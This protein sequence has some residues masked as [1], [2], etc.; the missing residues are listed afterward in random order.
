[1]KTFNKGLAPILLLVLVLLPLDST[2]FARATDRVD[3]QRTERASERV[4]A[5]EKDENV[6]ETY[7]V[8]SV[9]PSVAE[10]KLEVADSLRRA[11]D[12]RGRFVDDEV[13]VKFS[14]TQ[15]PVRVGLTSRTVAEA[16]A[17]YGQRDDVEY[18]EPNY[19]ATAF[20]TP[21]D[22][23][24]AYQWN[25]DNETTD[26]VNAEAAWDQATGEGAVVAVV[27]TGVA[28]ENY[29]WGFWNR[30]YQAPDL[31]DTNFVSGYD[32][33]NNDSHP[34]DDEGH[35]THVAGTIAGATNNGEGVA[36]LAHGA[37]IMPVKVLDA[38]GSGSYYDVAEG[39]RFAADN[40]ADVINLSLGGPSGASYLEDAV[41][42]AHE[43]GVTVVA[44]A[45]N[46][47]NGSVSYPAAYDDYVIAVGATR[48]DETL[49]SYSN[50]G[51]S[52]DIVAP[53]GDVT[54]DQNG[55]GYGDGVLQ[56]TFGS[57]RDDFGYY[58]YQG[59]SMAAPHVAA[60]AAMVMA[61][62]VTDPSEVQIILE[63]SADD[64]GANGR[65][66]TFG[67]GLLN[68]AAAL[69]V[70][71]ILEPE[72]D[73][74]PNPEPEPDTPPTVSITEPT[75]SETVS[76]EVQVVATAGDDNGVDQVEFYV[77]GVLLITD[78]TSP[79]SVT[80][81]S[82]AVA[83]GNHELMAVA[84]DTIDQSE[85]ESV[86]V[87]VDNFVPPVP[88]GEVVVFFESFE[89]GLGEWVRDNQDQWVADGSQATDGSESAEVD[90]NAVDT[91][92]TS[93]AVSLNGKD[94]ARISFDWLIER[95]LDT[96]EYLAFDL[97]TDGGASWQEQARLRG[98]QDR[99]DRWFS[100]ELE[101]NVP[102][103]EV[104]LRFRATMS[105]GNED[106]YVDNIV[107]E[108]Y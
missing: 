71:T 61:G 11:S 102:S 67:H 12:L 63:T 58:F 47:G 39:I 60:A 14:G 36:G 92:L 23:L 80:W 3:E 70:E 94:N 52:L 101:L 68:L 26:G 2:V 87:A 79:F 1:M 104:R 6:F 21:N 78:Y 84:Y 50:Y 91:T 82:T 24:Y 28:Y 37:S 83:D 86:V 35:G 64:L 93:P 48:F 106:A 98:N 88:E 41:R 54:V 51:S 4:A 97:S 9:K 75:N 66:N 96:G 65:D 29:G 22:P 42:Y 49:A 33:V 69:D 59:T 81:D 73:P 57:R 77:D 32:F 19:V 108:A 85:S 40:G 18:A 74:E 56:Q 31:A 99:E 103:G 43:Q 45:G 27:D 7:I 105:R 34:N 90:G 30:Y 89:S 13:V 10:V 46:D 16:L 72:P 44:A 100:E 17:D 95:R 76:G 5:I 38:N 15:R 8:D 53:G 62:G 55:D 107:V 25:F 20:V